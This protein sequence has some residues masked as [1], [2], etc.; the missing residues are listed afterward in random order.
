MTEGENGHT[1]VSYDKV[2]ALVSTYGG[3][4]RTRNM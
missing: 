3:Y 2:F 4:L 1:G